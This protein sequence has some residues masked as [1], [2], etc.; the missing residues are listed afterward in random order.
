[1]SKIY[2]TTVRQFI[3]YRKVCDELEDTLNV[4][5]KQGYDILSVI[6][7]KVNKIPDFSDQGFIII[8]KINEV[9]EED[10]GPIEGAVADE[11]DPDILNDHLRGA[12][13]RI[14]LDLEKHIEDGDQELHDELEKIR[15]ENWADFERILQSHDPIERMKI[16]H[17]IYKRCIIFKEGLEDTSTESLMLRQKPC[18]KN[19]KR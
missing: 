2:S 17:Y 9:K 5:N 10:E 8:Y 3:S 13:E 19:V 4:L 12:H 14:M 6:E 15:Q 7:T 18:S 1:M 16:V 11:M